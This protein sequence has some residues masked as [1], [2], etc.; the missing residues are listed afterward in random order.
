MKNE[1]QR[2]KPVLNGTTLFMMNK[3]I[4]GD[5][6][7]GEDTKSQIDILILRI[8]CEIYEKKKSRQN[9]K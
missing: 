2:M 3:F 8:P 7:T 1:Q 4:F 5:K 9:C 6:K